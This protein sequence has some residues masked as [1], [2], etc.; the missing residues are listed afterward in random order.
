MNDGYY[1]YF[2]CILIKIF[3]NI[4]GDIRNQIIEKIEK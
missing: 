4:I 3:E 1:G 2:N